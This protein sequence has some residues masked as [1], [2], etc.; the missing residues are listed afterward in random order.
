MYLSHAA[1]PRK[2]ADSTVRLRGVREQPEC[3][4]CRHDELW[5][6]FERWPLVMAYG[7]DEYGSGFFTLT[8]SVTGILPAVEHLSARGRSLCLGSHGAE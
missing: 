8:K 3:S 5:R 4:P 1:K 7:L 2:H 6:A